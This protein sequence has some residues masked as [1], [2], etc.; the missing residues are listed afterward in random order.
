ML[1]IF[2]VQYANLLL[3]FLAHFQLLWNSINVFYVVQV[4]ALFQ[5]FDPQVT[6]FSLQLFD[7]LLN[8]FNLFLH[9]Q[10]VLGLRHN[11]D[12]LLNF[13][14]LLGQIFQDLFIILVLSLRSAHNV[15]NG[16]LLLRL[17]LHPLLDY[18]HLVLLYLFA[19][20]EIQLLQL[21]PQLLVLFI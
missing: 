14:Q 16:A 10:I 5:L 18:Q 2:L 9:V 1:L 20:F 4:F 12:S 15:G 7:L 13:L 8:L 11:N 3:D 17:L 6:V 21:I 19:D